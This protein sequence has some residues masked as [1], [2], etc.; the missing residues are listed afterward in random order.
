[1]QICIQSHPAGP[2]DTS[3][4]MDSRIIYGCDGLRHADQ[5]RERRSE[6]ANT[7]GRHRGIDGTAST[8]FVVTFLLVI[9]DRTDQRK[10]AQQSTES[11]VA[12]L[13]TG[14]LLIAWKYGD[15]GR[16]QPDLMAMPRRARACRDE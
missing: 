10:A 3:E 5:S 16:C 2:L 1:M 15:I 4:T 13:A 12:T 6:R 7:H 9:H 14:N 8:M 11:E